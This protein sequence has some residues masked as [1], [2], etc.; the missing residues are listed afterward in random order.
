MYR[1]RN[2]NSPL[3]GSDVMN[4]SAIVYLDTDWYWM[5]LPYPIYHSHSHT[6]RHWHT[7]THSLHYHMD[8]GIR[9]PEVKPSSVNE[10]VEQVINITVKINSC[11]WMKKLSSVWHYAILCHYV[12]K[13]TVGKYLWTEIWSCFFDL[14]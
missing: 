6:D 4:D 12:L 9:K 1:N 5:K 3:H 8:Y 7:H 2:Q 14:E 11:T 13:T 10:L